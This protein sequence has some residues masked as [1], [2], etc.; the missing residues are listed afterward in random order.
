MI[1]GICKKRLITSFLAAHYSED[2][3]EKQ[4]TL[5][6]PQTKCVRKQSL[7]QTLCILLCFLY[8]FQQIS[9]YSFEMSVNCD[10]NEYEQTQKITKTRLQKREQVFSLL[11]EKV[12][13][14]QSA[15]TCIEK[16]FE[17]PSKVRFVRK[18]RKMAQKGQKRTTQHHTNQPTKSHVFV[19]R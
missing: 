5:V 7:F 1:L 10:E 3:Q 4:H 18:E 19:K 9:E 12:Q 8:A 17:V 11:K 15:C 13:T 2:R 16:E 14:I 6:K